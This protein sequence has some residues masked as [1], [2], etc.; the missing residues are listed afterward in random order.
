MKQQ[1][2]LEVVNASLLRSNRRTRSAVDFARNHGQAL[3]ITRGYALDREALAAAGSVYEERQIIQCARAVA[4]QALH[5][6]SQLA[7]PT[8]LLAQGIQHWQEERLPI[9][10]QVAHCRDYNKTP[11]FDVLTPR[12]SLVPAVPLKLTILNRSCQTTQLISGIPTVDPLTAGVQSVRLLPDE[13]GFVAFMMTAQAVAKNDRWDLEGTRSRLALLQEVCLEECRDLPR[14]AR[15]R[16]RYFAAS[17]R[18][19]HPMDSVFEARLAWLL[20]HA[21]LEQYVTQHEV[22]VAN[23]HYFLDFAFPEIGVA[24]EPDGRAKFGAT[25]REVHETR[26]ALELR[27]E[28]IE[29]MGW[30][31]V[32]VSWG[33]LA[34]PHALES[35]IRFAIARGRRRWGRR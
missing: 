5:A 13:C 27:R 33:E 7:G 24:L 1:E 10:L 23:D 16:A 31:M 25:V 29:S 11:F 2:L 30:I 6:D 17:R 21:G 18:M 19:A 34:A 8:A 15:G 3:K 14:R 9:Y 12:G 26:E 35:R 4:A 32:R 28:A 20:S 22:V